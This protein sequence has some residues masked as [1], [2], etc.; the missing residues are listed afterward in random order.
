MGFNTIKETGADL[1]T[2]LL[3]SFQ[4]DPQ[5]S[6][7]IPSVS[8]DL[9]RQISEVAE[10]SS[11]LNLF[12]FSSQKK[13][14]EERFQ[15]AIQ[16]VLKIL[17][18]YAEVFQDGRGGFR[19]EI[20]QNLLEARFPQNRERSI[21]LDILAKE[22]G[23]RRG[24][25][26]YEQAYD[27]IEKDFDK[28]EELVE[29]IK[30]RMPLWYTP[31]MVR[32][33]GESLATRTYHNERDTLEEDPE[34]AEG[35]KDKIVAKELKYQEEVD[36]GLFAKWMRRKFSQ[37]SQLSSSTKKGLI[38]AA[39]KGLIKRFSDY[40]YIQEYLQEESQDL[41]N[42]KGRAVSMKEIKQDP[43]LR[44]LKDDIEI[45]IAAEIVKIIQETV[46]KPEDIITRDTLETYWD[47]YTL[48]E[49]CSFC[50]GGADEVLQQ[51]PNPEKIPP[52]PVHDDPFFQKAVFD[53]AMDYLRSNFKV[54]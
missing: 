21:T 41:L 17:A 37:W 16:P 26:G 33:V 1:A 48:D 18:P 43:S 29:K 4:R 40:P 47:G 8:D 46:I 53:Q 10:Q 5:L 54:R 13:G 24:S 15:F 44:T 38:K 25:K 30:K 27:K 20:A 2:K 7:K 49:I 32:E 14:K 12:L 22:M 50:S 28:A 23:G 36:M 3:T 35:H 31:E 42:Y 11:L 45:Y 52:D 39:A 19:D 9:Q 34:R 51:S 6:T